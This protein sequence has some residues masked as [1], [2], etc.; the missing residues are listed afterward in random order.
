MAKHIRCPL[1]DRNVRLSNQMQKVNRHRQLIEVDEPVMELGSTTITV[2]RRHRKGPV[3]PVS[4]MRD[5]EARKL[6]TT[7]E[8]FK[9]QPG[10]QTPYPEDAYERMYG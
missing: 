5:W 3:C 7:L 2:T 8:A 1:C 10:A 4:G 9:A 6:K